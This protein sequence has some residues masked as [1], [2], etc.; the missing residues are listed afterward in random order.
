M[1]WSNLT[2]FSKALIVLVIA[3]AVGSAVYFLSPG[4]RVDESKKLDKLALNDQDVNNITTSAELPLPQLDQAGDVANKP[5]VRIGGYAWNAQSGIIVANGGAKTSKGSL[6]EKN[7]VRLELVRQ[8][9]L[10]ELRNL[11]MKFVDEFDKGNNNPSEGVAGIMIMGDGVPFYISSAQQALDDKYGKGKYQLQ[12]IAA[13]GLS[14]GEDKLIGPPSWKMNP[15]SMKGALVS[16]VI[17]D[18]DWVTT[19]NYA[20]ANGLKVNPDP[21]TYDAEAVNFLASAN[22]DYIES[23]KELIKSQQEG[24]TIPLKEVKNGKLTGKTINK[25]VDGC[26]T[27]TPGDKMVFDKLTGFTD[28]VST[29]EFNNQ[30]ATTVIVLRQWAENNKETIGKILRSAYTATN[31]MK[32]YDSWRKRASEAA[33]KTFGIETPDYWYAMFKGQKGEKNGISYNMGGS[34]VFNLADANQYYGISDGT[35]R[36]KAVYDQVSR[37]LKELNPAGFNQNVKRVVPYEEAVNTS[38]LKE[39]KDIDAGASY[40]TDYSQKATNV[41]ASAEWRINFDVGRASIRPEGED[42]LEQIYNL[43]IQAEDSKLELIGHTDN[44]GTKEGNYSL[45]AARAESVKNYLVKKGIPADRFQKVDGKGQDEP[46]EDNS[47]ASG[48]AKNR[49]VVITLLK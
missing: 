45:S 25:K 48:K 29:R 38:F 14:Y 37:Y 33:A 40:T 1:K 6:M 10:S 24:W 42:V 35:N 44:T 12:A 36:Y 28:V 2:F 8:D 4:L 31:Q 5:L 23:A 13:I 9:W 41:V 32:Q 18:G 17:G 3:G 7:G 46:I 43:L 30:M 11:H 27:W 20:F 21:S 39:I 26:A 47:T 49:R 15:Q 34:R 19:V 16:A 22:D